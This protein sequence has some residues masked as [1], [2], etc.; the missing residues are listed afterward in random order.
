MN[1]QPLTAIEIFLSRII[2]ENGRMAMKIQLPENYNVVE[3][4]GILDYCRMYVYQQAI[5]NLRQE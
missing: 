3:V 1:S 4:L 2:D 5:P